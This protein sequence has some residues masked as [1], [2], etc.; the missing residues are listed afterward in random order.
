[1]SAY[2]GFDT[3]SKFA[4]A[5]RHLR[6]A[7]KGADVPRVSRYEK[8]ERTTSREESKR[9]RPFGRLVHFSPKGIVA[10]SQYRK[11]GVNFTPTGGPIRACLLGGLSR[12]MGNYH[13]R[14]LGGL[15][16]ATAPGYPVSVH[17]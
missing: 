3:G 6:P 10:V 12:V 17:R 4:T 5:M 8:S 2:N 14:F 13:A 11:V 15:G 16:L 9:R 1:M 7:R